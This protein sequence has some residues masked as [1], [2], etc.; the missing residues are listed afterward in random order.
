M[1]LISY[2][3]VRQGGNRVKNV[4]ARGLVNGRGPSLAMGGIYFLPCWP[5]PLIILMTSPFAIRMMSR[6]GMFAGQL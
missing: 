1:L 6:R 5:L 4:A 2:Q 3:L